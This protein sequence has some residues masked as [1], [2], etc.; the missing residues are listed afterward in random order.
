V[1]KEDANSQRATAFDHG[2][3]EAGSFI[4][5]ILAGTLLGWLADRWLG[6]DPWLLVAGIV[7]GSYSGFMVMWR[8]SAAMEAP[9]ER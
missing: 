6:T 2:W 7:L 5:S 8:Q 3:V 1:N 9:R 4:G